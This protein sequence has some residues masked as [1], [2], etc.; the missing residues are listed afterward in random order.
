MASS[1]PELRH[2]TPD[3]R[4]IWPTLAFLLGFVVL[5]IVVSNYYLLPA[6][7]AWQHSTDPVG[8]KLLSA[9]SALL[10][11]IL[12]LILLSGLLLTF[13]IGRFF[14]PRPMRKRSS[15]QYVDVWSEAGKRI[16]K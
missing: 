7:D 6:L 9:H 12:L 13:R 10:L 15:T 16:Q 3:T 2:Q 5:L 8:K 4:R 11:A 14:F 1:S